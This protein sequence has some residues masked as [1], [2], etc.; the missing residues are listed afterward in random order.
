M[1]DKQR[2][3]LLISLFLF[4]ISALFPPLC[5]GNNDNFCGVMDGFGFIFDSVKNNGIYLP[6]LFVEWLAIAVG[7][8]ALYFYN[9]DE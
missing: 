6:T 4:W 9:K 2:K 8:A 3:L 7:Y 1:N 5:G